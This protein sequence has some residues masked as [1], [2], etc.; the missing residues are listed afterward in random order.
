MNDRLPAE[1]RDELAAQLVAEAQRIASEQFGLNLTF[2]AVVDALL[3][4]VGMGIAVTAADEDALRVAHA[5]AVEKAWRFAEAA[6]RSMQKI[7]AE[8]RLRYCPSGLP[9][10]AP[11]PVLNGREDG[12]MVE[13][14]QWWVVE[15]PDGSRTMATCDL[16]SAGLRWTVM[17]ELGPVP[18][19]SLIPVRRVD[20]I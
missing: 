4:A 13:S 5:A 15:R 12:K 10:D 3:A 8:E 18:L 20:L 17:D 11:P 16:L 6:M 2:D 14:G 9:P 7:H 1:R 19:H